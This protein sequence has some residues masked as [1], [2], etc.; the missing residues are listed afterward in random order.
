MK[1]VE[2]T[3]FG[4]LI[5]AVFSAKIPTQYGRGNGPKVTTQYGDILGVYVDNAQVFFGVPYAAPPT[6]QYRWK[7]PRQPA[8]WSPNIYNATTDPPAC[9]QQCHLPPHTCPNKTSEDCLSL[10]LFSPL[11]S[12]PSSKYPVMVFFHGGNFRQG[13]GYSLLQD[14]RYIANHTNTIVIFVNYRLGAL[15]FLV[16]GKGEGAATGNYGFLDQRLALEWVRDNVNNFGGDP[17]K[18]TIFGQSAGAQSVALHLASPKSDHLFHYAIME[19][20]PFTLPYRTRSDAEKQAKN[21]ASDLGCKDSDVD[22]MRGKSADDVVVAQQNSSTEIV[23]IFK[24]LELFEPWGPFV[25]GNEITQ[26][27]YD[28][29]KNGN[30]QKKPIIIGTTSDEARAN[31]F[32]AIPKPMDKLQYYE[33]VIA[34]LLQHSLKV[35]VKYPPT[36]SGDQREQL[37]A[38]GHPFLFVCAKRSVLREISSRGVPV[39]TYVFDH[40]MS[41]DGWGPDFS[42]CVNHSCHGSELPYLFHSVQLVGLHYTDAEKVLAD[43]MVTYWGNFAHTGNPNGESG[44]ESNDVMQ[45][46]KDGL[47]E[48]PAYDTEAAKYINLTTPNNNIRDHYL[49]NECDFWDSLH[50]YP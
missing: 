14:G 20:E 39:W 17:G 16:A 25:D 4:C 49:G 29:F 43:S 9:P 18:V 38:I 24:L 30:F 26:Q 45:G 6:G 19:S 10:T 23:N 21:F 42:F 8:S 34:I 48:W 28:A 37:S 35:L 5:G 11:N 13:S 41:F 7:P 2:L 46:V 12:T 47:I 27:S 3:C 33:Y 40:A 22:C 1:L 44:R 15:G 36:K 50:A 32:V 31:L